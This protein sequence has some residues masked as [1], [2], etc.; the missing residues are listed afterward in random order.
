MGE[1]EQPSA[2]PAAE[3]TGCWEPQPAPADDDGAGGGDGWEPL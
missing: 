2:E 3:P 1:H